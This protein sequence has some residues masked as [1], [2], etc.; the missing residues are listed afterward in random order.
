MG[1]WR[2]GTLWGQTS[3]DSIDRFFSGWICG[4]IGG[5]VDFAV[6]VVLWD[7]VSSAP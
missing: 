3:Q 4:R 7:R 5:F 1:N 6:T 2:I